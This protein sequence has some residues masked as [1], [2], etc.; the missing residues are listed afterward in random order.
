[1]KQVASCF[2]VASSIVF[3]CLATISS[4][5]AQ[6]VPDNTLPSNSSVMPG[7][8][9]CTINGGTVRGV[10]LFHSFSEFGVLT[11]GEANFNNALQIQNIF[12]RVTGNSVSNIDGVLGANGTANLF[13][14]N[15]NGIIFN[16]NA[17]LN[18]GGSFVASTAS[19]LL[20]AD[21][22]V[23]G[24]KPDAS[25]PPLLSVSVPIGLQYGSNPGSVEVR[26]AVLEVNPSQAL[27]LAGGNVTLIGGRLLAPG[28]R[29]ELAGVAT[30]G[31]IEFV[32]KN[33]S[34]G[35]SL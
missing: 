8:T 29:V 7:C 31:S 34:M 23:L 32:A 17:S 2:W 27:A 13:L 26:G 12:S 6:I 35:L 20:F 25:T 10:N 19:R 33:S 21:G 9:I 3:G 22:T 11:G 24:V 28:G 15:P 30:D 18:I 16:S 4:A 5:R 14:L 1:M